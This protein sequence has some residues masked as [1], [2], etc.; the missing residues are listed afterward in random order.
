M[1]CSTVLDRKTKHENSVALR[2]VKNW[3]NLTA[4]ILETFALET[5]LM[6]QDAGLIEYLNKILRRIRTQQPACK[7]MWSLYAG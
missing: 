2:K 7:T 4:K 6:K 3:Q 1:A 5:N